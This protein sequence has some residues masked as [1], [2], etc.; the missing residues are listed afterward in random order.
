MDPQDETETQYQTKE[1]QNDAQDDHYE[2]DVETVDLREN[3]INK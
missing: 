2:S 1:D 3:K